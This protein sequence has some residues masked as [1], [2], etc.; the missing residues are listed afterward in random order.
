ML[1]ENCIDY[2]CQKFGNINECVV[3]NGLSWSYLDIEGTTHT[4][5]GATSSVVSR[6]IFPQLV[7]SVTM[8]SPARG[9]FTYS[10]LRTANGGNDVTLVDCGTLDAHDENSGDQ[11]CYSE[12]SPCSSY[13]IQQTCEAA[14]CYWCNGVCQDTPCSV[15]SCSA[16]FRGTSAKIGDTIYADF[17]WTGGVIDPASGWVADMYLVNPNGK[18]VEYSTSVL[19]TGTNSLSFVADM[20]GTWKAIIF[21][22]DGNNYI[23]CEDTIDVTD[24]N[25]VCGDFYDQPT[26]EA[27]NCYWCN[28]KCQNTPCCTICSDFSDK[29]S[30]E[31]AN[32]H[33]YKKFI[34]EHESCHDKPLDPIE[35][36]LVY[37]GIGAVGIAFIVL[38][39]KRR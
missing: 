15:T 18:D 1:T 6:L 25:I 34:W 5:T 33:W 11:W 26:C 36:Y 30:C 13:F 10:Q 20:E 17:T 19:T 35:Q 24:G 37:G 23:H 2:I 3:S 4:E 16:K 31:N 38:I 22:W 39:A 29:T 21:V 7:V 9:T 12:P 32:C 27:A 14:E 8:I 28:G